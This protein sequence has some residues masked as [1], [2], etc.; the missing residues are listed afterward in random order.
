MNART[1]LLIGAGLA[2]VGAGG[3]IA[4]GS[5]VEAG[6]VAAAWVGIAVAFRYV[7]RRAQ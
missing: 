6:L 3:M 5:Y 2:A 4:R 7:G 1:L